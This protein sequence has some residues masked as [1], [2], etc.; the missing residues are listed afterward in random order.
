MDSIPLVVITGQV[1][2]TSIGTDAF[3]ESDITGITMGITKHNWLITDAGD[4]PRVVAEAFHVATTGRP[5]PVLIDIP[6]D[7]AQT[8]M[9]GTGRSRRRPRPARL[10]PDDRGDPELVRQAAE[11]VLAA[12]RPVIYAGGGV[13]KARASEPCGSWPS[14]PASRW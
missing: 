11:L 4:I 12:E 2:T 7:V 9:S 5:G 8:E 14:G 3:Q 1:A 10:P 6:K 13:L